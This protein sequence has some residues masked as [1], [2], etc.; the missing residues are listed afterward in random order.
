[1]SAAALYLHL[2][3]LELK[4]A[5]VDKPEDPTGFVI[6]TNGLEGR[7]DDE[8]RRISQLIIANKPAL[9]TAADRA[10]PQRLH[11]PAACGA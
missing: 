11:D 6:R 4:L 2:R 3:A 5:L 1:M 7:P 9:A 8:S 10:E